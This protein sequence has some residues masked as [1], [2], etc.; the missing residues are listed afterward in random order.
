MSKYWNFVAGSDL[1]SSTR[2]ANHRNFRFPFGNKSQTGRVTFSFTRHNIPR[3]FVSI[4]DLRGE[5]LRRLSWRQLVEKKKKED[6]ER[7]EMAVKGHA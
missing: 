2:S 3:I 4:L 7:A 5:K 1:N 6:E